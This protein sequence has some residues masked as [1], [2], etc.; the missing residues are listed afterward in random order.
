MKIKSKII[1]YISVF[2][3]VVFFS[4]A[5]DAHAARGRVS[6]GESK[7]NVVSSYEMNVGDTHD[8]NFYGATGYR[9]KVDYKSVFWKTSDSGVVSVSKNGEIMAVGPGTATI[10]MTV[11]VSKTKTSYEGSVTVTVNED[12]ITGIYQTGF[13][14]VVINYPTSEEAKAALKKGITVQRIRIYSF[15]TYTSNLSVKASI[16]SENNT[17]INI[18]GTYQN[19][20]NYLFKAEGLDDA[21]EMITVSWNTEVSACDLTYGGAYMSSKGGRDITGTR[22][23][24]YCDSAPEFVLYDSNRIIIGYTR[25]SNKI[26]LAQ[27]VT[28]KVKFSKLSG[29]GTLTNAE[30]GVVRFTGLSQQIEMSATFTP[31]EKT[32][33]PITSNTCTVIPEEYVYPELGDVVKGIVVTSKTGDDIV[34]TDSDSWTGKMP[35]T[36]TQYVL[37]YFEASDGN[38]YSGNYNAYNNSSDIKRLASTYRFYYELDGGSNIASLTRDGKLTAYDEGDIT[39]NIWLL[40]TGKTVLTSNAQI[41]GQIAIKVTESPRLSSIDFEEYSFS[42][43]QSSESCKAS[44]TFT[45]KDQYGEDYI[46]KSAENNKLLFKPSSGAG[47]ITRQLNSTRNGGTVTIDLTGTARDSYYFD[48]T[49]D[50]KYRES[51]GTYTTYRQ[52]E[53]VLVFTVY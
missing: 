13:D 4:P 52:I 21:G 42:A 35:A 34:W 8:L 51:D 29:T 19:N 12:K 45:F 17:Q 32:L 31:T 11:T 20:Q 22:S 24:G 28:G 48:I 10:S 18:D 1:L 39:V 5:I 7:D 33:S 37:F 9:Y 6:I 43:A 38:K 44:A 30:T 41:I 40:E 23:L 16:D 46:I 3:A 49:Y 15:G 53:D 26:T 27:G 14:R 47:T 50:Y 25:D 2:F 36:T